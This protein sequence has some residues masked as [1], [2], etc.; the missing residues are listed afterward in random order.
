M[1][2]WLDN[3]VIAMVTLAFFFLLFF[4]YCFRVSY[5][6]YKKNA[7]NT[8]VLDDKALRR[9]GLYGFFVGVVVMLTGD[10]LDILRLVNI[11]YT[12]ALAGFWFL[13]AIVLNHKVVSPFLNK[14]AVK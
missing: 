13:L 12:V 6:E 7:N 9:I 1:F 10:I 11:W 4:I 14:R 8:Y 5:P 2:G 3:E